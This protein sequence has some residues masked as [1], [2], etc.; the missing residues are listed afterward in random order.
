[1][2][3]VHA[4]ITTGISHVR[5]TL[6]LCSTEIMPKGWNESHDEQLL[7]VVDKFG[8]DNIT[9]KLSALPSFSKVIF[10]IRKLP[11]L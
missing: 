1:M 11:N 5:T 9:S 2:R 3:K 10:F 6:K 4:I 7:I 8:L